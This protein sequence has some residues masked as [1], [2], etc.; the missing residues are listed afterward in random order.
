MLPREVYFTMFIASTPFAI[1]NFFLGV[2]VLKLGGST[3]EVGLAYAA[4]SL[5]TVISR[6]LSGLIIDRGGLKGILSVGMLLLSVGLLWLSISPD[7]VNAIV[8]MTI[9][10]IAL[11]FV[12]IALLV[13]ITSIGGFVDPK[14]YGE[15]TSASAFGGAVAAGIGFVILAISHIL[16]IADVVAIKLSIFTYTL[17]CFIPGLYL[18]KKFKPVEPVAE[19]KQVNLSVLIYLLIAT[20]LQAT[21]SG[22]SYPMIMPLLVNRFKATVFMI[23]LAFI[24]A[25]T[26]WILV[27]MKVGDLIKKHGSHLSYGLSTLISAITVSLVPH[28]NNLATLSLLWFLEAVG[29]S[30]WYVVLQALIPKVSSSRIWG[31]AYG[32]QNLAYYAPY[33]LG[34]FVGGVL[35]AVFGVY[36]TF[37]T[38]A[39]FFVL[40]PLPLIVVS[41]KGIKL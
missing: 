37:Y 10:G 30:I 36:L 4:Y 13:Y 39:L 40:A 14:P 5:F 24:P 32:L 31:R 28:A 2:Y 22:I 25:G 8:S 41:L 1:I 35:Y 33:A 7:P 17:M 21:G 38:A 23:M 34:A 26:A 27:P 19:D 11:G 12:N 3:I 20:A 16:E 15:L 29:L 6:P 18:V 9:I